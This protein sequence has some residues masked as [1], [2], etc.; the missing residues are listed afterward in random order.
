MR[1][2][3]RL[4]RAAGEER[5]IVDNPQTSGEQLTRPQRI[6]HARVRCTR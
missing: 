3:L 2:I 1:A 6:D 5:A 4:Q